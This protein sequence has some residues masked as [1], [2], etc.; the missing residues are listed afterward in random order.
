VSWLEGVRAAFD[1][2]RTQRLRAFF[3]VQCTAVSVAFLIAMITIIEGMGLYVER[4][5]VGKVYGFNTV[6]LRRT[7]D[8][9]PM[10]AEDERMASRR[11]NLSFDDAAWLDARL[12]VPGTVAVSAS[13]S[14][15]V[16]VLGGKTFDRVRVIGA[17]AS[18]FSVQGLGFR[19]GRAFTDREAVRGTAVAVLGADVAQKLFQTRDPLGR[20]VT[21]NGSPYRVIGVLERRGSLLGMPLDRFVVV[22]AQST[23]NG[24]LYRF[25]QADVIAFRV[26]D[27]KALTAATAEIEGLMRSRHGL[28]PAEANDFSVGSSENVVAAWQ[29]ISRILLIAAPCLIGIALVAGIVVTMNIML[30]VVTER[31]WEIGLRKSVGARSRDIRWQFLVEAGTLS[32]VGGSVGV[33]FGIAIAGLVAALSPLPAAVAPWSIAAGVA[34]G[35]AVGVIAGVY[36]AHRAARL[37][38]IAAMQRE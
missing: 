28:R 18:H 23:V 14:A 4:N 37:D 29:R 3:V 33:A 6:Q 25:N 10:G 38:P 27:A 16:G 35:V 30:V 24:A 9:G 5:V 22:P 36:P 8:Q 13:G 34:M 19:R 31:T 32:G 17:S 15:R 12:D 26:R 21:V 7:P 11:P 2:L 1:T 20:H